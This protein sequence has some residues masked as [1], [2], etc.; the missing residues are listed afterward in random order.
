M[1]AAQAPSLLVTN[2]EHV[3]GNCRSLF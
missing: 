3:S 1:V 2:M